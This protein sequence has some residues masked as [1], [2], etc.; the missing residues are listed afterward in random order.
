MCIS[1]FHD[2]GTNLVKLNQAVSRRNKQLAALS[3]GDDGSSS[4][5]SS[6]AESEDDLTFD[7]KASRPCEL[8]VKLPLWD[9]SFD[10]S[11]LHKTPEA[12]GARGRGLQRLVLA[13][14]KPGAAPPKEGRFTYPWAQECPELKFLPQ[15]LAHYAY[16]YHHEKLGLGQVAEA[17]RDLDRVL[18]NCLVPEPDKC[19]IFTFGGLAI[20][21]ENFAGTVHVRARPFASDEFHGRNPQ[22]SASPFYVL[23][24][25]LSLLETQDAVLAIPGRPDWNHSASTFDG[26]K[27][28]HREQM[29]VARVVLFFKCT[30]RGQGPQDQPIHCTLA[31]VSRLR[32]FTAPDARESPSS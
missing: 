16:E 24:A 15:Q 6:G 29:W 5:T 17:Q 22:V 25:S 13:A 26:S 9:M 19:D 8:A 3:K 2:R 27:E 31:L 10:M 1:K 28:S 30:F 14:C 18:Q 32:E 12:L 23:N 4:N 21:C 20:R 7:D 11:A